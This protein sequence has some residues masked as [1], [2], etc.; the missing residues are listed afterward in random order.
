VPG[1]DDN[2]YDDAPDVDHDHNDNHID[3]HDEHEQ[4]VDR[5]AAEPQAIVAAALFATRA[6]VREERLEFRHGARRI[7]LIRRVVSVE[8]TAR[9]GWGAVFVES[10]VFVGVAGCG[11]VGG[12]EFL[13]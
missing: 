8:L 7:E 1:D 6:E 11:S 4:L 9:L 5:A 12:S 13:Y 10:D 3:D 2:D